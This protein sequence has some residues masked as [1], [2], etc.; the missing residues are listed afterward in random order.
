MW[1]RFVLCVCILL[2]VSCAKLNQASS[3]VDKKISTQTNSC[4][5]Q[6]LKRFESCS[7]TCKNS[8]KHCMKTSNEEA[9]AR[10]AQYLHEQVIQGGVVARTLQSYRDQL[11]CCKTTCDCQTDY[12]VCKQSCSNVYPKKLLVAPKC[13]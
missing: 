10:Y 7:T 12:L 11:Q 4:Y 6:C 8:C 1:R 2:S 13:C 9:S 5:T 3:V